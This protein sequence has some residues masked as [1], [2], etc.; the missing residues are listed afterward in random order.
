M[1]VVEAIYQIK[2]IISCY[3]L[4][5][6]KSVEHKNYTLLLNHYTTYMVLH[7]LTV[8][9]TANSFITIIWKAQN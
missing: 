1:L 6:C 8:I 4:D 2:S 7:V 3:P 9:Q 5:V